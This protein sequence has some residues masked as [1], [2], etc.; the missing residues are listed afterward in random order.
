MIWGHLA[1]IGVVA[2]IIGIYLV[3]G[4]EIFRK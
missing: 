2:A 4:W 1:I 3:A